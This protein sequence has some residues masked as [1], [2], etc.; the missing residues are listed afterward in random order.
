MPLEMFLTGANKIK[1]EFFEIVYKIAMIKPRVSDQ[2]TH[3]LFFGMTPY[4]IGKYISKS[5]GLKNK[6]AN[7]IGIGLPILT[8]ITWEAIIEPMSKYHHCDVQETISDFTFTFTG[9]ALA[10]IL[11]NR[12]D[13]FKGKKNN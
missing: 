1:E 8:E 10:Y 2:I 5:F 9:I 3:S 7:L 13:I 12:K 11:D 6:Y 4:F